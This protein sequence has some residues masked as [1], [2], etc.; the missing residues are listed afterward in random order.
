[1]ECE[2][3]ERG[4]ERE[5]RIKDWLDYCLALVGGSEKEHGGGGRGVWAGRML[6]AC[7]LRAACRVSRGSVQQEM[8]HLDRS[9]FT[10]K[11]PKTVSTWCVILGSYEK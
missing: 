5:I 6:L 1:M 9:S 7:L 10:R 2:R 11:D 3:R 8:G 4:R